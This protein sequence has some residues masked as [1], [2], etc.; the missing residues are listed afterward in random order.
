VYLKHIVS[1]LSLRYF[2]DKTSTWDLTVLKGL[3]EDW[4][5]L[6]REKSNPKIIKRKKGYFRFR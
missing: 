5:V 3:P 1:I 2:K 4:A 6:N